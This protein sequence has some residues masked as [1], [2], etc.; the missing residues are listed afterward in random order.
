MVKRGGRDLGS[1][2]VHVYVTVEGRERKM[3]GEEREEVLAV[4]LTANCYT[5]VL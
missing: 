1:V 4:Y 2:S 5:S 3:D